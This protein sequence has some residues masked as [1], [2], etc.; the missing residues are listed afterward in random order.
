MPELDHYLSEHYQPSYLPEFTIDIERSY[1]ST[2]VITA[3]AMRAYVRPAATAIAGPQ[4]RD[5]YAE[6]TFDCPA[7]HN[8]SEWETL[9]NAPAIKA[10]IRREVPRG[11]TARITLEHGSG[12]WNTTR[13]YVQRPSNMRVDDIVIM[14]TL[15]HR[16]CTRCG[17]R[18]YATEHNF[19]RRGDGWSSWCRGCTRDVRRTQRTLNTRGRRFGVEIE[20]ICTDGS[21][22]EPIDPEIVVDELEAA[23]I[24]CHNDGYSHQVQED[25]WKIVSDSSVSEGWE[26]VSPPMYWDQRE[27]IET[28]CR[29]L[30]E[31]GASVDASCGL[32]VHHEVRDL[33]LSAFKRFYSKWAEWQH[34][35]DLLVSPSRCGGQ[36]ASPITEDN[37]EEV[38]CMRSLADLGGCYIDR[39]RTLNITCYSNYGTVEI[40]QHQ[41]S[42]NAK[43]ILAWVAYGQAIIASV[44]GRE[45]TPP[46]SPHGGTVSFLDALPFNCESS[47]EYL[48]GRAAERLGV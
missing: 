22:G 16:A 30:D 48:K 26:L 24:V 40:R 13:F 43:K 14:P 34:H 35:H 19:Y 42:L 25:A 27:Q 39:Y 20:F 18:T 21:F 23:G 6:N 45:G 11:A 7:D 4:R 37:L 12:N 41:G 47:R 28:V 46:G 2:P 33:T 10:W 32:H 3:D 15:E 9:S 1:E 17:T 44:R 31:L 8:P 38:R 29:V 5:F 36:W